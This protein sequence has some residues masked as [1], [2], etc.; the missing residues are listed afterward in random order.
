MIRLR[1]DLGIALGCPRCGASAVGGALI[2]QGV[3]TAVR[4]RCEPCARPF[5]VALPVSHARHRA[6]GFDPAAGRWYG[7]PAGAAWRAEPFLRALRSPSSDAPALR[8]ERRETRSDVVIVN[9]LDFLYGHVLLKLLN[10]ERHRVDRER[11]TIVLIPSSFRW[12]VPDGVAEVWSVDLPLRRGHEHFPALDQAIAAELERF[13]RVW[14]SEARSHPSLRD[15][16]L[17]TR[18]ERHDFAS[19][20]YRITFVWRDDRPWWPWRLPGR[21][22]RSAGVRRFAARFQSVR[23]VR[24]M[25]RLR[26]G[27]P[28]ATF[29]VA[30]LGARTPVPDW[31][32]DERVLAPDEKAERRLCRIYAESRVVVGV[33]G[34]NLLLPSAHAGVCVDL[35]PIDRWGNLAQDLI[36]QGTDP[37]MASFRYRFLPIGVPVA[38]LARII[39]HAVRGVGAYRERMLG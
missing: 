1:P 34:S 31:I 8:I 16:R 4:V 2:W 35:M 23:M 18:T 5:V 28:E 38:Q 3:H 12:L 32:E 25:R 11:G 29:T 22:L 30:G 7:S 17:F 19:E 37:R 6:Y 27:L 39:E 9:C 13:E 14:L 26:R 15:I 10:V 36:Y 33:H 20:A 21:L 24:L